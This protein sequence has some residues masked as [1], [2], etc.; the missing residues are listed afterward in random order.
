MYNNKLNKSKCFYLI[1]II[2]TIFNK[3]KIIADLIINNL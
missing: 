1:F 3:E 2:L